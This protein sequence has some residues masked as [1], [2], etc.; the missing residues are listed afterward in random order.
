MNHNKKR[1]FVAAL[2]AC[3]I[4]VLSFS[5]LA[6]FNAS[7]SVTNRFMVA[8]ASTGGDGPGS[9]GGG[10]GG[11]GAGGGGGTSIPPWNRVFAVD[12]WEYI[13]SALPSAASDVP[14]QDKDRDGIAFTNVLPGV[15]YDKHPVVENIGNY[16]QW[17]RARVTFSKAQELKQAIPDLSDVFVG[18]DT[19]AW[20]LGGVVEDSAANTITYYYYLNSILNAKT[21]VTLF[22]DVKIPGAVTQDAMAALGGAFEM[23]I[24]ADAVQSSLTGSNAKDVF[25]NMANWP[26]NAPTP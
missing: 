9:T 21:M 13:G 26:V 25:E 16:G 12:I 7:E 22:T 4:S 20:T 24:S 3:M 18:L 1:I 10:G 11:G 2:A 8:S 6:W 14:E 17:I 5:T 23:T 19:N 15:T